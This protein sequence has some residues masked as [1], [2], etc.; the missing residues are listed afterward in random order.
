MATLYSHYRQLKKYYQDF[1]NFKDLTDENIEQSLK[2]AESLKNTI[3]REAL[4]SS[5]ELLEDVPTEN[6][7]LILVPYYQACITIKISDLERRKTNLEFAESYI[8]EFLNCLDEYRLTPEAFKEKRKN[9]SPAN[10]EEKILTFKA[11]KDLENS[12][13][14]MEGQNLEDCRDLYVKELELAAIQALE[15][16]DFIKLEM[17]MIAMRDLPRPEPKPYKPPTI[18]KIDESNV[19]MMPRVISGTQD[20]VNIKQNMKEQVFTNRNAPSMTIEEYGE[21]AKKE[22]DMREAQ[23][24][25]MQAE[26]PE[27]DSDEEEQREVK[28]KKDSEWD[29]WKDDHEKGAGN[30]GG[31]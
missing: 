3:R 27:Y 16:L 26:Q 18:V 20:L 24:K 11:K 12:I 8:D 4:F 2:L 29:N 6:I 21:W 22:M 23:T 13:K 7:P 10:R 9:P 14:A 31:R 30:R 5:N 28:R 15:H 25:K 19:H 1:E 17:Q